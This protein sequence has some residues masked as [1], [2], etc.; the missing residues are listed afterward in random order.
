MVY[1]AWM[2]QNIDR[3]RDRKQGL[4]SG[5]WLSRLA[6]GCCMW[7]L[8]CVVGAAWAEPTVMLNV[9][10]EPGDTWK[11]EFVVDQDIEQTMQGQQIPMKQTIG[12]VLGNRVLDRAGEDGGRWIEL[13]YDR[14]WFSQRGPA[15]QLDYDSADAGAEVPM[16]ARG[17]SGLVG[18]SLTMEMMPD[19]QVTRIEGL[20]EMIDQML[21]AMDLPEGPLRDSV[22]DSLE[23]QMSEEAIKQMMSMATAIYPDRAVAVGDRWT[24]RS[25]MGGITPMTID[26]TF[27]LE[28]FDDRHATLKVGGELTPAENA[29][30][31]EINGMTMV[32]EL[33]GQQSGQTVLD[34]TTGLAQVSDLQQTVAGRMTMT[35]PSGEV[36]EVDMSVASKMT[37]RTLEPEAGDGAG[38]RGSTSTEEGPSNESSEPNESNEVE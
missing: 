38:G 14:V 16:A 1:D 7:L 8:V 28:S 31:T 20:P 21:A 4:M 3:I 12:M 22:R 36:M 35:M 11:Q 29:Q 33:G 15:G 13:T 17:F 2:E 5:G 32:A 6:W 19:G 23:G 34:R 25:S 30:P 27:E 37:L 9:Q 10:V 18:R 26:S 24:D